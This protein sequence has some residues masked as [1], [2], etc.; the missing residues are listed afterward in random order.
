MLSTFLFFIYLGIALISG[1]VLVSLCFQVINF[2]ASFI[3]RFVASLTTGLALHIFTAHIL[4]LL[5]HSYKLSA[6][7]SLALA[8]ILYLVAQVKKYYSLK[9]LWEGFL[10]SIQSKEIWIIVLALIIAINAGIRGHLTDSDNTHIPWMA[11]IV[12]N[13]VYPP[14]LPVNQEYSLGFYHYGIDL[15]CASIFTIA[16]AMPWDAL[17]MQV[18][19]GA[20]LVVLSIYALYNYFFNSIK[21]SVLA[22]LFTTFFTAITAVEFVYKFGS[23]L[24]ELGIINFLYYWQQASLTAIGHIPYCLVLVSQDMGIAPLLLILLVLFCILS[25]SKSYTWKNWIIISL[26]ILLLAFIAYFCYD[27]YWYVTVAGLGLYLAFSCLRL[28]GK[29]PQ[30]CKNRILNLFIFLSIVSIAKYLTFKHGFTSFDGVEALLI[31]P[32]LYWDHFLMQFLNFFPVNP[33]DP[34]IKTVTD[35]VSGKEVLN[36]H[37]FTMI[38]FRN[39]GFLVLVSLLIIAYKLFKKKFDNSFIFAC[40][41]LPG[42]V[43]PFVVEFV[44]KPTE[45][46][47]FPAWSAIMLLF[48]MTIFFVNLVRDSSRLQ[49]LLK[50]LWIRIIITAHLLFFVIPGIASVVPIFGHVAYSDD[51]RLTKPQKA[52]LKEIIRIHKP[53]EIAVTDK[54]FY[55]LSDMTNV[56]GFYGV[57]GQMYK[58]DMVTRGT[59]IHLMNPLLLQE[60]GVDYVLVDQS[61][62]LS[63]IARARLRHKDLFQEITKINELNP[64]WRFYKF[65]NNYKFSAEEQVSLN[66]EYKW[67][68]GSKIGYQFQP[69]VFGEKTMYV[70]QHRKDLVDLI[71]QE[72]AAMKT[73]NIP[74]AMWLTAEALT[75][76]N[77]AAIIEAPVGQFPQ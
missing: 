59:V 21:I 32:S 64:N 24:P 76:E 30:E 12:L 5:T 73:T 18:G 60:L 4:A 41:A 48:F 74:M 13:N 62:V 1:D 6:W 31:Q 39:F 43:V 20:F 63:P 66:A 27:A 47:R 10:V 2:R 70:A 38:T 23:K 36:V 11:G 34:G 16:Q 9:E 22:C 77:L 65:V 35:F 49:K 61:D 68:V 8:L 58:A 19:I 53:G 26:P 40:I 33:N 52:A 51:S 14:L 3:T 71:K 15:L 29:A 54:L 75:T 45:T 28:A 17:S 42:L 37:L 72:K 67:I 69:L 44:L 57:G 46:Y 7:L 55:W 50:P 25:E 56:A